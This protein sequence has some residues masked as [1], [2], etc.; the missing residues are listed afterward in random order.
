MAN[1]K[2]DTFGFF[3]DVKGES[4][5]VTRI[6]W[7]NMTQLQASRMYRTTDM[8]VPDN[9]IKHGWYREERLKKES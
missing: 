4:G 8:R 3:I 7:S 9:I 2:Y 1:D 5:E 6:V